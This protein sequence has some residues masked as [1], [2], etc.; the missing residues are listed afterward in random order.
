MDTRTALLERRTAHLWKA[1]DAGGAVPDVVVK[2]A[3]EAAHHAPC[4]KFT[5]P[6]G[7]VWAGP[8][9]RA[10]IFDLGISLKCPNKDP[11]PRL[12]EK[13]TAKMKNPAHM[14]AVTQTIVEDPFTS[15]EDYAAC[16]CAIQNMALSIHADGFASKWST[17]GITTHP[18]AYSLLGVNPETHSIIGFIWI[19]VPQQTPPKPERSSLSGHIRRTE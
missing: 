18:Q 3:I 10:E 4:H 7:F 15:K 19:G 17:G 5:W 9:T 8:E 6:W 12:L 11:S 1:V 14:V 2:R 16:A 13:L